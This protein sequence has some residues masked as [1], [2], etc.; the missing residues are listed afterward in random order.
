MSTQPVKSE[1]SLLRRMSATIPNNLS[2]AANN[3]E[4]S[5]KR[6]VALGIICGWG[7]LN[8]KSRPSQSNRSLAHSRMRR[9]RIIKHLHHL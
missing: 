9:H 7:N 5:Y 2:W 4:G 1:E 8:G 3:F 6:G